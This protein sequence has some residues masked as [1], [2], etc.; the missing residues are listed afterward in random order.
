MRR[1]ALPLLLLAAPAAAQPWNEPA[2]PMA[3]GL[4][5]IAPAGWRL[6]FAPGRAEPDAAQA[7]ALRRIGTRLQ[8]RTAG[9]VTLFAEAADS[10]DLS[11]TRRL[12]LA[13]AR[14]VSAALVEGGLAER[15]VDIHPAGAGGDLVD[16]LPPGVT[17][18]VPSR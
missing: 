13:R 3:P 1:R 5:P 7:A 8:E 2:L 10:G 12:S 15:R 17:R 11:D 18:A 9:R 6:L 4:A 14:A 16:I